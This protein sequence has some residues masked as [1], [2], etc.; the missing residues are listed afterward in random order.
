MGAGGRPAN[1][2]LS[3][4]DIAL[5]KAWAARRPKNAPEPT[6]LQLDFIKASEAEDVRRKSA[7]AQRARELEEALEAAKMER[8]RARRNES[9]AL[10]ALA[11][12]EAY[13]RPVNA[14]KLALAAWPR[15]DDDKVT[16]KLAET[17]DALARIVPNLRERGVVGG[18][19][20]PLGSG[21]FS[22]DGRRIVTEG[23]DAACVWDAETG[24]EIARFKGHSDRVASAVFSANGKRVVTASDDKTARVWH[25]ETG[26]EIACLKGHNGPVVVASFS[27]EGKRVLTASDDKSARVWDAE[28][29]REIARFKGH[30]D[31]IA[32]AAFSPDG[33]PVITAYS[34]QHRARLGGPDRAGNRMS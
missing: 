2:L 3:G 8:D 23:Y 31:R 7:D 12:I 34:R 27:P 1:R 17:L 24:R 20:E 22:P 29:G 26:R 19:D 25:A 32:S 30:R 13:K 11:N 6:A 10:T 16:P 4:P 28:T 15:D 33:Q 21:L 5:A 14:A 9:V 18:H